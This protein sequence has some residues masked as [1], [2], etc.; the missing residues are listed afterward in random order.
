MSFLHVTNYQ[1]QGQHKV[2]D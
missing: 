2:I 1:L